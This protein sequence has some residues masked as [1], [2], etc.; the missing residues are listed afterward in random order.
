M[1]NLT[2][3]DLVEAVSQG[4]FSDKILKSHDR[5]AVVLTQSWCPQWMMMR[6][7]LNRMEEDLQIYYGEYE[8][9]ESYHSFMYFKENSFGNNLVPYI[10]FYEK[11]KLIGESNYCNRES[12]LEK[13][14]L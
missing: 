7:W 5:V 8:K 4:D 2:D 6:H 13:I 10:R 11:G 12:F 9:M 1:I 14:G 3:E